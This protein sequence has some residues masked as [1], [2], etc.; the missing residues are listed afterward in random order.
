MT[1]TDKE[2]IDRIINTTETEFSEFYLCLIPEQKAEG[3]FA[4]SWKECFRT[5]TMPEYWGLYT[6]EQN[7]YEI[8]KEKYPVPES[9]F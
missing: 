3:L 5:D 7:G 1:I 6:K 4:S 8:A 2:K 9:E